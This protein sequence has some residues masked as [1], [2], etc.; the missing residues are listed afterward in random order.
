MSFLKLE[1]NYY[2]FSHQIGSK[3]EAYPS[4]LPLHDMNEAG[5]VPATSE[6][7]R[8]HFGFY[9]HNKITEDIH[10]SQTLI[11]FIWLYNP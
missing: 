1:L 10:K 5:N 7:C 2:S 8:N 6:V 11:D 4:I 3:L 9:T